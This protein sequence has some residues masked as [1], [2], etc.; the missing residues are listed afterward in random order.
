L[1]HTVKHD[2]NARIYRCCLLTACVGDNYKCNMGLCVKA[3]SWCDGY[4]DC[5]DGSDELPGC[6][7]SKLVSSFCT[8]HPPRQIGQLFICDI[9]QC[10][11]LAKSCTTDLNS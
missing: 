5:P 8:L 11:W 4:L 3:S 2:S 10:V 6:K 7:G 1:N 9:Q